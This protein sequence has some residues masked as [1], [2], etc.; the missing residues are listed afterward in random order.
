[1]TENTDQ[2]STNMGQ[3]T[4]TL[5]I[6]AGNTCA[7]AGTYTFD[8]G[9]AHVGEVVQLITTDSNKVQLILH[10]HVDPVTNNSAVG[11]PTATINGPGGIVY[12]GGTCDQSGFFALTFTKQ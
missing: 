7:A 9:S 3:I 5:T 4:G 1:M 10:L 2:T 12:N 6:G 8:V 11:D